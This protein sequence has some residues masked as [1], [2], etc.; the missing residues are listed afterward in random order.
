[1]Q[2]WKTEVKTNM[3]MMKNYSQMDISP[4]QIIPIS[5]KSSLVSGFLGN[6]FVKLGKNNVKITEKLL[7]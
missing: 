2:T 1:M 7:A 3:V 4:K 6:I 5:N